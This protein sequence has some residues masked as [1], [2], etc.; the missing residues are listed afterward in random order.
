MID[1]G[2]MDGDFVAVQPGERIEN[3]R[4][5][6]VLLDDEATV[7]RIYIQQGRIA[8]QPANKAAGYRTKYI[9]RGSERVRIVG[10]VVGCI[11]KM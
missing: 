2:I 9:R 10:K 4:I 1:E 11:R 5:G 3:G 8:L 6:V 7:K